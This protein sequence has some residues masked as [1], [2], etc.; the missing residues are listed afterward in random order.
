MNDTSLKAK[1]LHEEGLFAWVHTGIAVVFLSESSVI[2][3][4]VAV[5]VRKPV[6]ATIKRQL[7]V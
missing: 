1:T 2:A 7:A 6:S 5:P 3:G 4:I